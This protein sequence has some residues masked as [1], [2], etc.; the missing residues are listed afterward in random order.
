[1][2]AV[3]DLPKESQELRSRHLLYSHHVH[4]VLKAT[5]DVVRVDDEA[6]MMSGARWAR[7]RVMP[8]QQTL[9]SHRLAEPIR[10]TRCA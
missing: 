9:A 2:K 7:T 4:G 5:G 8:Y 6:L 10:Q 1:M 3:L